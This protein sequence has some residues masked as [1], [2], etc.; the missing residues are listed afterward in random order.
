MKINWRIIQKIAIWTAS[1]LLFLI[2]IGFFRHLVIPFQVERVELHTYD[3]STYGQ[4]VLTDAE[5]R[6]LLNLHNLSRDSG[7]INGEPC[8]DSYGFYIY[9][10]NGK[11][12]YIGE[13]SGSEM[14]IRGKEYEDHRNLQNPLLIKYIYSLAEK[15]DMPIE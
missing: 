8:C 14:I 12:Q 9:Y 5:A 13:G 4:R 15:Y 10:K 2:L 6:I 11:T 3:H 7:K 1:I